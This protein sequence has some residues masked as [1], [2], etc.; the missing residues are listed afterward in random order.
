MRWYHSLSLRLLLLFWVLFFAVASS[1]YLL[2]LWF[3]KPSVPVPV[4]AEVQASLSPVLSNVEVFRSLQPGRLLAGDYRV[5]ASLSPAGQERL[6][7]D[8][9]LTANHQHVLMHQLEAQHPEQVLL[10]NRMLLGPFVHE[11][12]RILLTRPAT[13][14]ETESQVISER[15]TQ[16]IQTLALLF[17]S[18]F[19]AILLG[20]WLVMPLRRLTQ[21]TRE[22]AKGSEKP[23]LKRLPKRSDELGQLARAL[24]TTAHDL[25]VSRDA[26]RRLLSDVSHEL[27]SPLARMQVALMLSQ[28]DDEDDSSPERD[29]HLAQLGRDLERL[30][31]IIERILSLSRLENGLITLQA[32][33]VN[34]RGLVGQLVKDLRYV[35]AANGDRL[36]VHDSDDW[37]VVQSDPELLRLV[38]EN[39]VRNA[40]QY[41]DDVVELSC[42]RTASDYTIVIRDHG[43]GVPEEQLAQLFT[44]F[45]RADP[46]RN[47]KSGVGLGMALSLRTAA[48]LGGSI[49]A[50]NHPEGGLEVAVQLPLK[51][52]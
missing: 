31:A 27:R 14:A 35:N 43:A 37:P 21:A 45:Y 33:E 5:A 1:G 12:Y 39:L 20:V 26:Q 22:I 17:G 19:I 6:Q 8:R 25:A 44:P 24:K 18:F 23:E 34:V 29:E 36:K 52:E 13:A 38:V 48:V 4:P 41:T 3:S 9:T 11:G 30:S 40:L 16:R 2:A 49:T 15:Q 51:G 47:H 46:S 10:G 28:D 42:Q 7:L 32:E 50:V